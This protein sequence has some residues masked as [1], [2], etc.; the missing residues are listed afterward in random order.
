M[1]KELIELTEMMVYLEDLL[2]DRPSSIPLLKRNYTRTQLDKI[3]LAIATA[4][5]SVKEN[6]ERQMVFVK[7]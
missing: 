5:Y 3:A 6:N 1:G 7:N 2:K 4:G